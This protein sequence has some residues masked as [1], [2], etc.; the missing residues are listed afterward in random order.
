MLRDIEFPGQ[1]GFGL[2]DALVGAVDSVPTGTV[3]LAQE[4]VLHAPSART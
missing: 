1:M 3:T 2:A 4:V